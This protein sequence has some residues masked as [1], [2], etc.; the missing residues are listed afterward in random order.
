MRIV[1]SAPSKKEKFNKSK[2]TNKSDDGFIESLIASEHAIEEAVGITPEDA[3]NNDIRNIAGMIEQFG[4]QLTDHPTPDNFTKY[5]GQIKVFLDIV[6]KNFEVKNK[7]T[8]VGLSRHKMYQ[9]IEMI[10]D[11]LAKLAEKV[12]AREKKR[13]DYLRLTNDIKGMIIDLIM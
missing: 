11:D 4:E 7:M 5:K 12:M 10:D 9:I 8:R 3:T 1:K 2:F 6:S 13:V